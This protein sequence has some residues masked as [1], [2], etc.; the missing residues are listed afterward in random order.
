[1]VFHL[2]ASDTR[3]EV[4][5]RTNDTDVAVILLGC[6]DDLCADLVVWMEVG[7][8]TKNTQRY[9]NISTLYQKL[10]KRLSKSL[11]GFHALTGSDYSASFSRR[12]KVTPFKKL[13]KDEAAQIA[14]A[15]LGE[16]EN[17]SEEVVADIEKFVCQ[18]YGFSNLSSIDAVRLEIFL[19]NY[20]LK[21]RETNSFAKKLQANIPP[22]CRRVLVEKVRRTNLITAKW[23]S[24]TKAMMPSLNPVNCGYSLD[25]GKYRITWFSGPEA[26]SMLDVTVADEDIDDEEDDLNISEDEDG[27]DDSDSDS[28]DE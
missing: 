24:A 26:P 10:G 23:K 12:G 22:P 18:L 8:Y 2:G 11:P 13:Q 9:I 16:S 1:M 19:K 6:Y 28:D 15:N 27:N 3:G 25:H 14:L 17:I 7:L 4:V 20:Q 5:V 21:K